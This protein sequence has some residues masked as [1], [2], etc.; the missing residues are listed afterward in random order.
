MIIA[1]HPLKSARL[2]VAAMQSRLG[3]VKAVQV[4]H[5]S[6]NAGMRRI[7]ERGPIKLAIVAPFALLGKITAHEQQF[8]S[9]MTPHESKIS[10]Q[11][12]KALPAIAGHLADQRPFPV[13]DFVVRQR[14]NEVLGKG[15]EQAE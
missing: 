3:N 13:D 14:Q 2:A 12:G 6:L 5:Q 1:Y 8:L 11:V 4:A 15:V 9:R 10:A 7:V